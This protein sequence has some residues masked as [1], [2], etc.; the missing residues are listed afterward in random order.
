MAVVVDVKSAAQTASNVTSISW[1]HA[2]GAGATAVGVTSYGF[3]NAGVTATATYG[4][5]NMPEGA[6]TTDSVPDLCNI[7]GLTNLVGLGLTGTQTVQITFT[8]AAYP[9]ASSV[10]VTGADTTTCFSHTAVANGNSTTP[11][12]TVTSASGEFV[13]CT[14]GADSSGAVTDSGGA[15]T[16]YISTTNG[17]EAANAGTAP[18]AAT[19]LC[20]YTTVSAPWC[21][22]AASFKAAAAFVSGLVAVEW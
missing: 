3:I 10:T 21:C 17:G 13:V 1:S 20:Q 6:S 15:Q 19:V 8:N 9:I 2:G 7:F 18:G 22:V 14:A 4:G 5:T 16:S 11:A 12:V